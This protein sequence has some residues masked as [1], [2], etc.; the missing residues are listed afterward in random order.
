[1]FIL[2]DKYVNLYFHQSSVLEDCGML[3]YYGLM[4]GQEHTKF[5]EPVWSA[6]MIHGF[7]LFCAQYRPNIDMAPLSLPDVNCNFT[8]EKQ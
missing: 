1:M 5:T 4:N 6:F 3:Q 7:E 8:K 2:T